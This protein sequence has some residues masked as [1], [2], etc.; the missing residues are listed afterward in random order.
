[1][2][3]LFATHT[4]SRRGVRVLKY[5]FLM[6]LLFFVQTLDVSDNV[7][8]QLEG[9]T[10]AIVN[11]AEFQSLLGNS[12]ID[13][14]KYQEF[15]EKLEL[16]IQKE[17][18]NATIDK[19]GT[20]VPEQ[21]GYKL[22]RHNFAKEFYT[23]FYGRGTK[24]IN[25]P[26][27]PIY[28][29]V[30]SELLANIRV[31]QIGQYMTYFNRH[32]KGRVQ[33]IKLAAEAINNHVVFPGEIFSFNKVVGKRT[34]EK[35][36]L[37]AP[38]IIRGRVYRD[39]GGGIC[40]VSSTL[41]NAVDRA[42]VKILN[43]YSHS[44]RVPYV[45]PGRDAQVSWYGADFTFENIHNQP[46]LIQANVYGGS[47]LITIHSSDVINFQSRYVPNAPEESPL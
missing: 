16:Q 1:M 29:K 45:P 38:V 39:F 2:K 33:N 15:V 22:D 37:P 6:L 8:L 9:E 4:I 18:L 41:F 31:K 35:G 25:V 21:L 3:F 30:D 10:V 23:Y 14:E 28:P 40:Q 27:I 17:P 7:Y 46:I 24:K 43:R 26:T 13:V 36:Y 19:Y 44:K 42:G 12:L 5:S 47:L 32:K 20:V 11:R 34:F